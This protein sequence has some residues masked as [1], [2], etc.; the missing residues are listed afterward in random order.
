MVI[1]LMILEIWARTDYRRKIP[2]IRRPVEVIYQ[3]NSTNGFGELRISQTSQDSVFRILCMGVPVSNPGDLPESVAWAFRGQP[4][5]MTQG[6]S[7]EVYATGF[8]GETSLDAYYEYKYL[9][10][11]YDFDLIILY[12]GI[13]DLRMNNCPPELFRPDYGHFGNY[14]VVN[15][16]MEF[17]EVPLLKHS[18]FALKLVMADAERKLK[19]AES[20]NP[21]EFIPAGD[22]RQEWLLYGNDVKS[23]EPFRDNLD[24]IIRLAKNRGQ[25]VLLM[26]FAHRIPEDYTREGFSAGLTDYV[27]CDRVGDAVEYYGSVENVTGGLEI[28]NGIIRDL[29]KKPDLYFINQAKLLA[30]DSKGFTDV[31]RLSEQGV[32][33]FAGMTGKYFYKNRFKPGRKAE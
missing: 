10:A 22:P 26:T 19:R 7:V 20:D 2:G 21:D 12:L 16:A 30:S 15:R 28:H 31:C 29:A 33:R 4:Y 18:F 24:K 14:R 1:L 8:R 13:N 27:E 23:A 5:V 11:G 3:P 25:R 6:L 9:Y 17:L 32:K